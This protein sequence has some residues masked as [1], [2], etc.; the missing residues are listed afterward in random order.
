MK[1]RAHHLLCFRFSKIRFTERGEKYLWME[2]KLKETIGK[3]SGEM[4]EVV[5]GVD[6]LCL[7]CPLC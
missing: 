2:D 5:L 4:V 3:G 6:D 1:L 7:V